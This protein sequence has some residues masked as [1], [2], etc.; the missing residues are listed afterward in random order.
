VDGGVRVAAQAALA[1]VVDPAVVDWVAL[2]LILDR[3]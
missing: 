3:A 1:A 2:Q